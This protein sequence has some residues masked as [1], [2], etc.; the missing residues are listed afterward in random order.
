MSAIV[1]GNIQRVMVLKLCD[2][3]LECDLVGGVYYFGR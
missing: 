1:K 2:G 3:T